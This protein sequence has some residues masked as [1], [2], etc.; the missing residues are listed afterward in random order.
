[1]VWTSEEKRC[2]VYQK[3]DGDGLEVY[4]KGMLGITKEGCCW[5]WFR[6]GRRK[7][8]LWKWLMHVLGRGAVYVRTLGMVWTCGDKW[9]RVH[10]EDAGH[11][12]VRRDK[13]KAEEEVCVVV[14]ILWGRTRRRWMW[15]TK[16]QRGLELYKF[17]FS[18]LCRW[19]FQCCQRSFNTSPSVTSYNHS[20]TVT[21][22]WSFSSAGGY[23]VA[24]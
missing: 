11:G 19:L 2:W 23:S 3:G 21:R 8:I 12:A 1:M 24:T 16:M 22:L 10:L 5:E 14:Q 15:D 4:W 17:C 20:V 13:E 6:Y 9:C 7:K 18:F